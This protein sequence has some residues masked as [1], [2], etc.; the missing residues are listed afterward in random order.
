MAENDWATPSLKEVPF[1]RDGMSPEEYEVERE[2]LYNNFFAAI[3]NRVTLQE[4]L[5]LPVFFI[6]IFR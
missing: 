2:Y 3:Q 1:W 6:V 5:L 4:L